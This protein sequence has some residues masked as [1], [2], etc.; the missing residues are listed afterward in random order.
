VQWRQYDLKPTSSLGQ[1]TVSCDRCCILTLKPSTLISDMVAEDRVAGEE[2]DA[3]CGEDQ[4]MNFRVEALCRTPG[5]LS[6]CLPARVV[7]RSH[8]ISTAP[9]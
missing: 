3:G 6:G 7:R 8:V 9:E 4:V 1:S 2:R 5:T